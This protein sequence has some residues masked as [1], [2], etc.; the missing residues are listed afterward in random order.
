MASYERFLSEEGD[1]KRIL[2]IYD[3]FDGDYNPEPKKRTR[4]KKEVEDIDNKET[5]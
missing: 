2:M 1:I 5:S 4:K 3:M